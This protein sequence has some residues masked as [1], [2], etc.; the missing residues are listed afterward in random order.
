MHIIDQ[1]IKTVGVYKGFEYLP[2]FASVH[3]EDWWYTVIIMCKLGLYSKSAMA[4]DGLLLY[5]I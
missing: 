2:Y 4:E 5:T 1:V 3:G